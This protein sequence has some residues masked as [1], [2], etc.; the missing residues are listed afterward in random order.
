MAWRARPACAGTDPRAAVVALCCRL[1]AWLYG[2]AAAAAL[3][4]HLAANLYPALLGEAAVSAAKEL[5]T[6]SWSFSLLCLAS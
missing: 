5:L 1:A 6:R 3:F 4:L 2:G